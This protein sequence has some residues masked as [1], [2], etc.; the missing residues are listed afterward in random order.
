MI[1]IDQVFKQFSTRPGA[2]LFQRGKKQA[3]HAVQGVSVHAP[4]GQITGLLGPNGAGKT[5]T[6]RMLGGLFKPDAGTIEVDGI[7]VAEHPRQALARMGILGDAHGLYPRLSARENITY[8]GRL[9]GM[10]LGAANARAEELS[11]L[12]DM[13]NILDRRTE[14]FSQGERMKTALARSLVHDPANIVLD[15]PTN[16]LDVLATRSLRE[17]LR[18]LCSPEGG[19][20]C[21]IFSTHIMPEVEQLCEN[22]IV[23]SNGRSVAQG[24]VPELLSQAGEVKFEDAFVKLA[25]SDLRTGEKV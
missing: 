5:T 9:Q 22:V 24:T 12:L 14:G 2:T 19:G 13:V 18:Y 23:V 10:E 8:F 6:L 4:N 16:G 25:F 15:E 17:A 3:I 20:K 21:I 11:Q 7:S 1:H